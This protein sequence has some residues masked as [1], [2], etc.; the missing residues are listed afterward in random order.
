MIKVISKTLLGDVWVYGP[1]NKITGCANSNF[2][3]DVA[4]KNELTIVPD[5]FKLYATISPRM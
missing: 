5:K 4:G 3:R 2:V 1:D